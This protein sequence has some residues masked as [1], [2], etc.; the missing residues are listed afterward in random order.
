[1]E[2]MLHPLWPSLPDCLSQL[3]TILALNPVEEAKHLAL[4]SLPYFRARK[5]W[6]NTR[7]DLRH[8]VSPAAPQTIGRLD[9][10]LSIALLC[11]LHQPA[12]LSHL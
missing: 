9:I 11:E 8:L 10:S 1:M 7:V 6:G 12:P 3:P 5:A 4:D 2:Q